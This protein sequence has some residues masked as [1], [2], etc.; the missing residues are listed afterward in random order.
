MHYVYAGFDVLVLDMRGHG[1]SE[2]QCSYDDV[3]MA[4]DTFEV[5][6][7][8][9]TGQGLRTIGPDEVTREGGAA[10]GLLPD[11]AENTPVVLWGSS[12]G[13]LISSWAMTKN[14][15][16]DAYENFN[17]KGY[18]SIAG[19]D[20]ISTVVD[21]TLFYFVGYYSTEIGFEGAIG[22]PSLIYNHMDKWPAYYQAKGLTDDVFPPEACILG[23]NRSLGLKQ[24]NLVPTGHTLDEYERYA[25]SRALKFAQVAALR[26]NGLFRNIAQTTIED[27]V[28]K[29]LE[30]P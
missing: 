10:I 2:G 13:T 7:Q 28:C 24:I 5:L 18:V 22:E 9:E 3:M 16:E 15:I 20:V 26:R 25:E 1:V 30:L 12:Q 14:A 4:E 23:Y 17:I 19:D 27:E 11:T 8:L 21:P 6:R 29:A